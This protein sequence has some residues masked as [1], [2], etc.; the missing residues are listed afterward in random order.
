MNNPSADSSSGL[1]VV[2]KVVRPH[3]LKGLL[4]IILYSGSETAIVNAKTVFFRTVSEEACE[5][6]VRS[7][8]A[9]KNIFLMDVEGL[10]SEDAAEGF[11][12]AEVLI[13][14]DALVREEDAFFWHE[15]LGLE[16]YLDTGKFIG[17]ISRILPTGANDIY[18][19][20]KGDKE[21]YIPAIFEVIKDVDLKSGKMII[22]PMEGLLEIN[23]V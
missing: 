10:D 3:G 5:F 9:H 16:V 4:R 23:E 6:T 11:R 22:S 8:K 13:N 19:V 2:G 17:I 15:L 21:F 18:V 14:K 20:R 7:V 12:D 1:I